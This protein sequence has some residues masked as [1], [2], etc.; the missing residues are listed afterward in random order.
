MDGCC[1]FF[2]GLHLLQEL[3]HGNLIMGMKW[4]GHNTNEDTLIT[5]TDLEDW[6][7]LGKRDYFFVIHMPFFALSLFK[8]VYTILPF[9]CMVGVLLE[10]TGA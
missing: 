6:A 10:Y 9:L 2:I 7:R 3:Q 5:L 8:F 4:S 1:A